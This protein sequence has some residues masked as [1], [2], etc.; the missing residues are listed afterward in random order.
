MEL[1]QESQ[2]LKGNLDY[3]VS[4]VSKILTKQNKKGEKKGA[5]RGRK[6]GGEKE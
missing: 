6:K 3:K 2:E 1:R 5:V 4:P